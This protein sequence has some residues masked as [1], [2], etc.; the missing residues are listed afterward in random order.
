MVP[1]LNWV[2]LFGTAEITVTIFQN[3]YGI[4][5]NLTVKAT[6]S[7]GKGVLITQTSE[8]WLYV[9][10]TRIYNESS[11]SQANSSIHF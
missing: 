6:N 2:G 9:Q 1:R 8:Y 4:I 7:K 11:T 3:Q 5:T 10:P